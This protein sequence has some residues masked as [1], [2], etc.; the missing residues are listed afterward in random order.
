VL[1]YIWIWQD[2]PGAFFIN[3]KREP[4]TKPWLVQ[5]VRE[6]LRRLGLPQDD[7]TRHILQQK[8]IPML[9]LIHWS[10]GKGTKIPYHAG[11][12]LHSKWC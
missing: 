4:V 10:A 1:Y 5:Q 2:Q 6:T 8:K 11:P 12:L 3:R 9:D 7:Y